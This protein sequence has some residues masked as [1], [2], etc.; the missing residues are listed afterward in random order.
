MKHD[1]MFGSI[2]RTKTLLMCGL[3]GGIIYEQERKAVAVEFRRE[4][5]PSSELLKQC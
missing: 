1:S 2:M 3:A 5:T 4:P